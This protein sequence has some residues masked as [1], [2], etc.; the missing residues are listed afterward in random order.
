MHPA[1]RQMKLANPLPTYFFRV[2]FNTV[3]SMTRLSKWCLHFS[4][5]IRGNQTRTET[6]AT[7]T[8]SNKEKTGWCIMS[9]KLLYQR[10][11]F[12]M[13]IP[14]SSATA[15]YFG[16]TCCKLHSHCHENLI[17]NMLYSA[18][19]GA[20]VCDLQ[21]NYAKYNFP[22]QIPPLN[23]VHLY[24]VCENY[25]CK[26]WHQIVLHWGLLKELIWNPGSVSFLQ[27]TGWSKESYCTRPLP[28]GS[29]KLCSAHGLNEVGLLNLP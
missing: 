9:K 4:F 2:Y 7:A 20:N 17:S 22:Y 15:Q 28:S 27:V 11:Q 12:S 25:W 26:K 1:F 3:L 6:P 8:F 23:K 16:G 24:A 5:V 18:N 19:I 10:M 29:L 14:C 21:V 13:L